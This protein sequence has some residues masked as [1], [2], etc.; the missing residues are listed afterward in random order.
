MSVQK[1]KII[2]CW[3][4]GKDSSLALYQILNSSE[5]E[6][7]A[8]LTTMTEGYDRI[9]MH[10]V[11][12]YLLLEQ[13]KALG[14]PLELVYI[15]QNASNNEYETKMEKVLL[16]FKSEGIST[17]A[18]GDIF[19]EDLRKYREENL[20]KIGMRGLF[21]IWKRN[22]ADLIKGFIKE[23]FVAHVSCVDTKVLDAQFSGR[24]INEEFLRD[25][26]M[27]V[28]PCGENG[29][30]HSF[31]SSG[32]IFDNE[33]KLKTGEKVLRDRFCFCD[34]IPANIPVGV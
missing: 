8:L 28:D 14:F 3:S 16:D 23:G 17:V 30:F 12:K 26:P 10:G 15:S 34:L 20:K 9:S 32:P 1:E 31:V 33:V 25:L 6:V 21:P 2:M 4:G 19:L 13:A 29:E 11:R 5:F 18:F 24:V 7:R 27:G 22:T